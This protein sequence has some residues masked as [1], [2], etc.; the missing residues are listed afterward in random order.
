MKTQHSQ[1]TLFLNKINKKKKTYH[2]GSTLLIRRKI[3]NTNGLN[4]KKLS[5]L[6]PNRSLEVDCPGLVLSFSASLGT[7]PFY[8]FPFCPGTWLPIPNITSWAEMSADVGWKWMGIEAEGAKKWHSSWKCIWGKKRSL[9]R[10]EMVEARE[11][12]SFR[13]RI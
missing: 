12:I 2:L 11:M 13:R 10:W 7:Q 4:K 1:K 5:S 3:Q 9:K 6:T 8:V